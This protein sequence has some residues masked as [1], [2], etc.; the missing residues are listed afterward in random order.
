[1]DNE[2]KGVGNSI[3]Y[4]YRMHDPRVGRFFAVDPLSPQYPWNSPYAF[5]ENRVVDAIELEGLESVTFHFDVAEYDASLFHDSYDNLDTKTVENAMRHHHNGSLQNLEFK[6][7]LDK[8]EVEIIGTPSNK[9]GTYGKMFR[10]KDFYEWEDFKKPVV[11]RLWPYEDK[12][13]I[14]IYGAYDEE[15][16]IILDF[17]ESSVY[18]NMK[19]VNIDVTGYNMYEDKVY[20]VSLDRSN[21]DDSDT[22]DEYDDNYENYVL[23]VKR[24]ENCTWCNNNVSISFGQ[25][26][27]GSY[28]DDKNELKIKPDKVLAE[29]QLDTLS[30]SIKKNGK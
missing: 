11:S 7:S 6:V 1:M 9:E 27:V 13:M 25:T 17:V 28:V 2:L 19:A 26:Y 18:T 21:V 12:Y 8:M 10:F 15:F 16:E 20:V 29:D 30:S 3:N 14:R 4:K 24:Q 22:M 23:G 5:S